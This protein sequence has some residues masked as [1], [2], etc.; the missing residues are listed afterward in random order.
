MKVVAICPKEGE[1]RYES[2][3]DFNR[4][5]KI[6]PA[7]FTPVGDAPP[8]DPRRPAVC[9]GCGESL[10]FRFVPPSEPSRSPHS[11]S[12]SSVTPA[13]G[14]IQTLFEADILGGE[15]VREIKTLT[16][17]RYLVVTNRRIVLVDVE[18]ILLAVVN[19]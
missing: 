1:I 19:G 8:P 17:T 10:V 18:S 13:G 5:D 3:R 11:P 15:Q 6:D 12:A 9:H 7:A 16:D 14:T 2:T 4:G